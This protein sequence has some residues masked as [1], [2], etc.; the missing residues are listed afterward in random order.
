MCGTYLR[1]PLVLGFPLIVAPLLATAQT[2]LSPVV[3]TA[4]SSE[5]AL[6]VSTDPK[7]ARQPIP[8]HD[9][10]D[11]LKTIAGFSVIRKGGADGDPVLRGMA[12]S[13]LGILVDGDTLLGGCGG[14]MDPPT[15]YIYPA[16]YDEVVVMKGPQSVRYGSG[17]SAGVVRFERDLR[18]ESGLHGYLSAVQ[19]S[20]DRSDQI[21]SLSAAQALGYVRLD[22]SR[23]DANNYQDGNGDEVHSA[24]QRWSGDMTLGWTPSTHS[25]LQLT[26]SRSDGEARYADRGMDGAAFEREYHQLLWQQQTTSGPLQQWQLSLYNHYIDHVMDNFSLRANTGKKMVSNPDRQTRGARLEFDW[27]QH[28]G[29]GLHWQD[30]SHRLRKA[31]HMMNTPVIDTVAR[32]HSID[33]EQAGVWLE[34]QP[35]GEQGLYAGLRVDQHNA[36]DR[37]RNKSTSG[38][39]QQQTLVSGFARYQSNWNEQLSSYAGIGHSQR[40]A[41]FWERT[42]SPGQPGHDST[43]DLNSEN[44]TQL[45]LGGHWQQAE[46]KGSVSAFYAWHQD[47]ILIEQL[48]DVSASASNARS[49]DARSWGLETDW[50]YSLTEQWHSL[51]T[52]AWVHAV[53]DTDSRPLAQ[54]PPLEA[55]LGLSYRARQWSSGLLLRLVDDQN[56]VAIGQG[57]IVGQDI[58]KTPGFALLSINA[59]WQ[60]LAA[61]TLSAGIDNLFDRAYGEHLSK[62]GAELADYT[63]TT[64][65]NE[66]GRTAWLKGEWQF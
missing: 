18:P 66:P 48:P 19:G 65:V 56:R 15:A 63:V 16:A 29:A 35:A 37:R 57:N 22:G 32:Q 7:A 55:R 4:P 36:F 23:S 33:H 44:L 61:V 9:G 64:R 27:Q 2:D 41:D 39:Q 54:Q 38:D 3:I 59:S 24:Y 43:F 12:G 13:R 49:I 40:S 42:R 17:H 50:Q 20:A 8:A 52:L 11:L 62:A 53:N 45:D 60:P 58:G 26:T 14:R 30:D 10:A 6:Q 28:W 47:Y 21:V 31:M 1:F 25:L 5:T 46:L 51:A 34:Y